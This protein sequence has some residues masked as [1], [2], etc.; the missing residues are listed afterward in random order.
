MWTR[1]RAQPLL[2]L[3]LLLKP[4]QF[5]WINDP[6]FPAD[7]LEEFEDYLEYLFGT[8]P[9]R[10]PT[11]ETFKSRV[12]VDRERPLYD[13]DYCT[14]EIKMKNVHKKLLCVKEHFFLQTTYEDMQQ[15]CLDMFV[16][17]KNGVKRCHRSKQLV[18]G[19]HCVLQSGYRMPECVYESSYTA[20]NVLLTCEWQNDIDDLFPANVN[21]I[22]K[23]S[24]INLLSKRN[25]SYTHRS[26]RGFSKRLAGEARTL[27]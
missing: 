22:E 17:C 4:L 6:Q 24:S 23:I 11:K 27:S 14:E 18:K 8:G 12:I 10:P 7:K 3:F 16:P 25:L 9:T 13:P 26:R 15:I 1:I 5:Q 20:G 21:D 19:V 2:L